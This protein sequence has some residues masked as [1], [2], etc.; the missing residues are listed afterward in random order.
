MNVKVNDLVLNLPE[1]E[2]LFIFPSCGDESNPVGASMLA[3]IDAGYPS[4]DIKPLGMVDWGAEYTNEEVETAIASELKDSD[5]TVSRE[6]DINQAIAQQ[7][8]D[9]KVVGRLHGRMEWGARSLGHR[10]IL[11]DPRNGQV[12]HKINKA[13]K[14]RDFWM[15][16]AP[17]I[18]D[19]YRDK[20]VKLRSDY[21]SPF[22][23]IA[24][25]SH[26]A[27][28]TAIPAGLHPFDKTARCQIVDP[29]NHPSFHDLISKYEKITGVGGVLNTSFNLH[30]EAIVMTPEDAIKTF[31][32]SG[33]D[34]LQ[35]EDY[36]V[37]K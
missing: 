5:V 36:M 34:V 25:E 18:L 13:I 6:K 17:A 14:M 23:T 22:M 29:D 4:E 31:M 26:E 28:W 21:R 37:T 32:N 11:A 35:M 10:S 19:T 3:A 33:L 20:Y 12:I 9:G 2:S 16:F 30:G 8:A 7:I 27:A 1:V 15:P 24:P